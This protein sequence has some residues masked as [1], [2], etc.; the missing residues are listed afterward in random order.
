MHSRGIPEQRTQAL[1]QLLSHWE[2]LTQAKGSLPKQRGFTIALSREAG[3]QGT[4]LAREVGKRLGW[5]V[6][7]HELIELIAQE[8]G[9]KPAALE[10]VDEKRFTWLPATIAQFMALP[11]VSEH[12]YIRNLV[13]AV[14]ALAA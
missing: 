1:H 3:T 2:P 12:A 5:P 9:T 6:F 10:S 11:V 13:K 14:S 8:M 4:T 7:D